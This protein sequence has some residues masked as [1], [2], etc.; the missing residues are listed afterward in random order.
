M[1]VPVF[2]LSRALEEGGW[3]DGEG[4]QRA[5]N[6]NVT[7]MDGK[8]LSIGGIQGVMTG[9]PGKYGRHAAEKYS[10]ALQCNICNVPLDVILHQH[11]QDGCN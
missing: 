6:G 3:T 5:E 10:L 7:Q 8:T 4:S 2:P 11:S 9:L 1:R